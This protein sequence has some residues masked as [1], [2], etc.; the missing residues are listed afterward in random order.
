MD[1][2]TSA[3][4]THSEVDGV[5]ISLF[6]KATTEKE[7]KEKCLRIRDEELSFTTTD[8]EGTGDEICT[9]E[10]VA[11]TDGLVAE[12][13]RSFVDMVCDVTT[14]ALVHVPPPCTSLPP[15]PPRPLSLGPYEAYFELQLRALLTAV[16]E[17]LVVG[18]GGCV[19]I[20]LDVRLRAQQ[21]LN[22]SP[23]VCIMLPD[24]E[25]GRRE[26]SRRG[27]GEEY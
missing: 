11:P 12:C 8:I 19:P 23:Y 21:D 4:D 16:A 24:H 22:V 2:V 26:E 1:V 15:S 20:E 5:C 13:E 3:R 10:L 7:G 9:V 27:V 6:K 14:L 17:P 25:I 18:G